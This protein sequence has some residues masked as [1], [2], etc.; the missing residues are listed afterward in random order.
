MKKIILETSELKD[1]FS[2]IGLASKN[3]KNYK[4]RLK[5][6]K[7]IYD[8]LVHLKKAVDKLSRKRE[9]ILVDCG[10]GKSYLSFIAN[11]YLTNI[12]ERKVK[13]I[14]VDYNKQVIESS[15][16]AANELGLD[17][18]EFICDDIF[19]IDFEVKPDIV[20]S[21]H[22][23]DT[24][25][26]MTIA[27]GIMEDAKYIMTVSCCQH[28]VRKHFSKHPLKAIT[29]HGVYKERFAD[30]MADSMRTLIL[31][32]KGYKVS[33]FEYVS[34]SE[35]PK[36]IMVRAVK[37]GNLSDKTYETAVSNYIGLKNMFNIEPK[38]C[39]YIKENKNI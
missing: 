34:S 12:K 30:M 22:A 9:L 21:L 35:T 24:A 20:Y 1:I 8:Y 17:N 6:H 18:M 32:S 29:K 25:T 38:L 33:L 28:T 3:G 39:Q 23:C 19:N 7:Q 36:N 37:S 26:D 14:C 16:E 4:D 10:C 13:F 5:K 31:E 27:K 2:A 15:K 11:Y